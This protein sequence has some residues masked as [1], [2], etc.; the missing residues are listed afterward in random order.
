MA[1]RLEDAAFA[2][3]ECI[4]AAAK[5]RDSGLLADGD[6]H[7]A[8]LNRRLRMAREM[9]LLSVGQYEHAS[10]MTSELGRLLGAWIKRPGG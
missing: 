8:L 6:V 5:K 4:Q 3:Q 7:L 9:K 1:R 10:R 2:F